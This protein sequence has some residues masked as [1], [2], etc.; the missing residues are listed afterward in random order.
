MDEK[1]DLTGK[2][3]DASIQMCQSLQQAWDQWVTLC[4]DSVCYGAGVTQAV[5][6]G[7]PNQEQV[8]STGLQALHHVRFSLHMVSQGLPAATGCMAE[9]GQTNRAK[10]LSITYSRRPKQH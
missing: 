9:M 2:H 10:S 8:D 4:L 1:H 3:L 5:S 7:S 6:I